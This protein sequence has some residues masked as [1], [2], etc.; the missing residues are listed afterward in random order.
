MPRLV[1]DLP[2]VDD[3][4]EF[5]PSEIEVRRGRHIGFEAEGEYLVFWHPIR[6]Q[7]ISFV[8]STPSLG[9]VV[10]VVR[11]LGEMPIDVVS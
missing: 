3:Y 8:D 4:R 7:Y 9:K 6:Q 1:T 2:L 11:M 10:E 5:V